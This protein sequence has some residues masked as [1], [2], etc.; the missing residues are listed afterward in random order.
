MAR[1]IGYFSIVPIDDEVVSEIGEYLDSRVGHNE[2]PA[3]IVQKGLRNRRS[4]FNIG[5]LS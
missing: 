3:C 1:L 4:H 5:H 2:W